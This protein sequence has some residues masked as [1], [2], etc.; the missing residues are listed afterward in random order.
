[1]AKTVPLHQLQ[2][3][4][5]LQDLAFSV[6]VQFVVCHATVML[7]RPG[8]YEHLRTLCHAVEQSPERYQCGRQIVPIYVFQTQLAKVYPNTTGQYNM[9]S[10]IFVSA[11]IILLVVHPLLTCRS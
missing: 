2:I 10:G 1:M 9:I 11:L 7:A 6:E 5:I 3:F 8:K 4:G